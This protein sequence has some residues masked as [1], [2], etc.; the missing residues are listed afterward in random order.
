MHN[1]FGDRFLRLFAGDLQRR[2]KQTK[3]NVKDQNPEVK[4]EDGAEPVAPAVEEGDEKNLVEGNQLPNEEE[5]N[6]K[7]DT[8]R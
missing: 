3:S 8:E 5:Q 2:L 7:N 4:A 1:L 6:K